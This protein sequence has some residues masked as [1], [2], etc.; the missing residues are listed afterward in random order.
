MVE[1]VLSYFTPYKTWKHRVNKENFKA[2]I[3]AAITG[4]IVVLPQ[5]VAFATI[6][7]M[8]PAYGLYTAM[9]PALIAAFFGSSWHLV[10][11]PTTAASIMLFAF[12]STLAEPASAQ[13]V[14]LALTLTFMVGVTE[15]VMGFARLGTLVNF[16][17]HAVVVGF[18]AGAGILIAF[19]QFK[20]F[21]GLP[22]PRGSAFYEI[23]QYFV[24]HLSDIN[25]YVTAVGAATLISGYIFKKWIKKVPYMI[26]SMLIGSVV[27]F[28]INKMYGGAEVTGITTVGALTAAIP[29]LSMP[30]FS[31]ETFKTLAPAVLAITLLAL[32]EAVAIA[33]SIAVKSGQKLDGNQEFVG[34]GLSNI[35]GSFFS[36]YVATGS[37]NRSGVNYEAGA[38]TPLAA[39]IAGILLIGILLLVAPWA[40]YLPTAAMAGILFLVA[41]GIIDFHSIKVIQKTSKGEAGVLWITF[42]ATLFLHLEFAIMAGV[43]FSFLFYLSK[44]SRPSIYSRVP[45]ANDSRRKFTTLE[46]QDE[47]PQ[48][49][50]M[51][52]D[53]SLFFG[54]V[55]YVDEKLEKFLNE[56]P[57]QKHLAL[58]AQGINFVDVAGAEFLVQLAQKQKDIGGSMSLYKVKDSVKAPL[59]N[60]EH[61]AHMPEVKFFDSKGEIIEDL[62]PKM[63][64]EICKTCTKRIFNE[65]KGLPG[66]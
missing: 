31:F 61:M 57:T 48:I 42:F 54:S 55:G 62:M 5:G 65:C 40:A 1:K 44:T 26:A 19:K 30:D 24:T 56:I 9:I 28:F 11:G 45:N 50:F 36:A 20:H 33:R 22:I 46:E 43:I 6:A 8:P 2:D 32:T 23:I 38:K 63:D 41:Y 10:S 13:Y 35:I 51:R 59:E 18:T 7:G 16:I 53:G 3:M 29:P 47:C 34:Q 21:F 64:P 14:T 66:A 15:V 39:A 4:A 27:G 52:V 25:W 58:F 60:G 12:L 17:S 49:K 37:F